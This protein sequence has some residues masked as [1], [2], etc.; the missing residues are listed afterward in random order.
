VRFND[1][2][3]F[4]RANRYAVVGVAAADPATSRVSAVAAA[5]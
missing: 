5:D 2:G 4:R 3:T 1:I